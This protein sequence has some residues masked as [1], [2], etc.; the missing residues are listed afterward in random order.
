MKTE[1]EKIG[2]LLGNDGRNFRTG[3]G[4]TLLGILIDE[5]VTAKKDPMNNRVIRY[6]LSDGS[7]ILDAGGY[8]WGIGYGGCFCWRSEGH[9]NDCGVIPWA[10]N[11]GRYPRLL[12]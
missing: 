12:G 9:K 10:A 3:T 11:R 1:A 5:C 2:D 7:T 8:L 4:R 6:A